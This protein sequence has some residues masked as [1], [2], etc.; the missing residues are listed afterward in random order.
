MTIHGARMRTEVNESIGAGRVSAWHPGWI[1]AVASVALCLL[2]LYTIT[3]AGKIGKV[4]GES[5][6][7]RQG[8]FAGVGVLLAAGICIVNYRRLVHLVWPIA[9]ATVGL[10]L[11]PVL[12]GVPESIVTPR[13]GARRWID[14][15]PFDLQPAELGKI[16]YVILTAWYL[17]Y[18][19][20]HRKFLG[21]I[22]PAVIA[23]VPM[24]L[25]VIEPDLGTALLFVPMMLAML[26]AAGAKLRHL[27]VACGLVGVAAV[28]VT[29][30]SLHFAEEGKYP[31]LKRHQVV[32]IQALVE[33]VKGDTRHV[34]DRGFQG[35]QAQTLVGAGGLAGHSEENS[36]SL[37]AFSGLP[38]RHNDMIF[39]V[40]VNRF[41]LIGAASVMGL[42]VLWLF[43]AL[44]A[45]WTCKDAF[46]RLLVVGLTTTVMIQALIN[47]G[48]TMGVLPITGMTL[49]FV[50]YGGSSMITGWAMVGLIMSVA[51]R[52]PPYLWR[53]SFEY[54]SNDGE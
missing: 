31:L 19:S 30:L 17:R 6:A 14:L 53:K 54:D 34:Q 23:L 43:G 37:V 44:G 29:V 52:R 22:G 4:S 9:L 48:E 3:L 46:G 35:R 24:V 13:N 15:G 47:M 1:T 10:L 39:A 5:L 36:R 51:M 11:I 21:L 50:S 41:G 20:N 45:A 8:I 42:Y 32:R 16:A 27:F 25:I 49:P 12:P 33:Q 18:R 2:G 38:E 7:L 26:V 40:I 28:V